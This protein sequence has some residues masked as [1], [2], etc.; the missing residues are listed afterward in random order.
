MLEYEHFDDVA[1]PRLLASTYVDLR[2]QRCS[3]RDYRKAGNAL[4]LHRKELLIRIDDP[5]R[6]DWAALTAAL[7]AKGLFNDPNLIG[8]QDRWNAML[9]EAG[10][11]SSGKP[12]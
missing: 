3:S 6:A 1:F 5:R 12:L 7:E 11:D 2:D 10:L 9:A 4:I 8:R